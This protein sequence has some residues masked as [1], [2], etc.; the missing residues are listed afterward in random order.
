[1]P[2]D[3]FLDHIK[4]SSFDSALVSTSALLGKGGH[5]A[6]LVGSLPWKSHYQVRMAIPQEIKNRTITLSWHFTAVY[7]ATCNEVPDIHCSSSFMVQ[8][9]WNQARNP[10]V[11]GLIKNATNLYNGILVSI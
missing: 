6:P 11:G 4:V 8:Q 2:C 9:V 3:W 7:T 1:M 5:Y 10:S